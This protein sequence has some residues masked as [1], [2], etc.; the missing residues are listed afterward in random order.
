MDIIGKPQTRINRDNSHRTIQGGEL[1]CPTVDQINQNES[2]KSELAVH[3]CKV[4]S[5]HLGYEV[6]Y[7]NLGIKVIS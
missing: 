6:T 3:A 1:S 2:V 5:Q 4:L 7:Q